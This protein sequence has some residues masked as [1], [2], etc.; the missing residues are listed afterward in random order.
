M[1]NELMG[2]NFNFGFMEYGRPN[3]SPIAN[4]VLTAMFHRQWLVN[5]WLPPS[6]KRPRTFSLL[7]KAR[8]PSFNASSNPS[9]TT[10]GQITHWSV[11]HP[12]WAADDVTT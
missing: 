9:K 4:I 2:W 5:K 7:H 6:M 10:D 1:I 3:I 11:L 12:P 8:T